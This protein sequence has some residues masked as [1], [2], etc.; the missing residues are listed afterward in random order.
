MRELTGA[1]LKVFVDAVRSYFEPCGGNLEVRTAYLSAESSEQ[2]HPYNGLI[3]VSGAFS[4]Q[5]YFS[6][7]R[8]LMRQ[9]LRAC[10]EPMDSEE[11][12]LDA[13]GEVANTLAG[14]VR[15]HFGSE[16][17]ISTPETFGPSQT[18][19]QHQHGRAY[20]IALAWLGFEGLVVVDLAAR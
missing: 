3:R 12:M 14:S 4:G 19:P 9:L 2:L 13:A 1:E 10:A 5:I 17:E 6:A 11:N 20:T 16:L 8:S 18:P 15:R 7:P